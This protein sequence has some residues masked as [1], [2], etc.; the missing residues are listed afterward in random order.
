M[1]NPYELF[2]A[3]RYLLAGK[4]HP[5]L[6]LV[7]IIAV[8]GLSLGICALIVVLSVMNG[9]ES[10]LR[11]RI[12]DMVSHANLWQVNGK[13][14][15]WPELAEELRG[16]PEVQESAPFIQGQAMFMHRGRVQGTLVRGILPEQEQRVSRIAEHM[17]EG[18][19]E[20]LRAGSYGVVLGRQ[21]AAD[22]GVATGDALTLVSSAGLF[23][24][25]GFV[26][27]LRRLRVVGIFSSDMYE[28]DKGLAYMSM[29]DTA[30]VFRR[31]GPA[32]LRLLLTDPMRAPQVAA[33]LNH[34]LKDRGYLV[35]DWTQWHRG[36][37]NALRTEKRVMFV[38]LALII[39]WRPSTSF[40]SWS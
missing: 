11:S 31:P 22:L 29:E 5:W 15:D 24:I 10:E 35:Q 17:V 1:F 23:S 20:Q 3:L 9:F 25:G 13:I 16:H 36:F 2:L 33:Q 4:F 19:L 18:D 38:I 6:S 14:S 39:L 12:L 30:R 28:Y 7:S 21:L 32:G 40:L 8:C 26:P 37:F 27:R 34:D